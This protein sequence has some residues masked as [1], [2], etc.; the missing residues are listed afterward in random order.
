MAKTT[1]A[2]L[3]GLDLGT[4]TIRCAVACIR[5]DGDLVLEGYAETPSL[6][7]A[8]GLVVDA[9]QAAECVSAAVDAAAQ[10][11]GVD[12]LSVLPAVATPYARGFNSRGCIG[13]TR[14]DKVVRG[15]EAR[16]ALAAARRI[17]LPSDRAVAEIFSQGFAVDET[18]GIR[19]PVGMVGGRLEAEVHIVTDSLSAQTN[20]EQI[21][22]RA[23]YRAERTLFGPLAAAEAVLTPE[24][25][26]L[27]AAH[28]HIG[29]GTT[30]VA[31]YRG[32]YPRF[33]RVLPIGCQHITND[34]AI[35]LNTSVVEA[36]KLKRRHGIPA[37]RRPRRGAE[38]PRVEVPLADGSAMQAFPLWRVGLIVRARVEEIFELVA[39]EVDRSGYAWGASARAVLTG[40]YC[41]MDGALAMAERSLRRPVRFGIAELATT[42][43]Q[44]QAD[45][46]HAVVLGA[47]LR[48]RAHRERARDRR[49][50][51]SG[52][53][54]LLS[55][56]A[57]WL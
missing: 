6:G 44:F 31:L 7:I 15:P 25:K 20:A 17:A 10:R 3:I 16:R 54:R 14:D 56:V 33:S 34:L 38:K 9:G 41:R 21:V 50:E 19:N 35:G 5:P 1:D 55:R 57:S 13:I 40:G 30:S 26:D 37:A 45:P 52:L 32:G 46:A 39:R 47:V 8:K 43:S 48:G 28:V 22:A 2:Y 18:R 36:E 51:D 23:G 49:F 4:A 27:G 53:R 11:A 42:L 24:E 29:A 12:V